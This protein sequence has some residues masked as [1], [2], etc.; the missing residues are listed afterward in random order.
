MAEQEVLDDDEPVRLQPG[1]PSEM[2]S[3]LARFGGA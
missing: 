1:M 2:A 3:P